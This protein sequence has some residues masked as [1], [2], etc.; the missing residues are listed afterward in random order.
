MHMLL[1]A[2]A[3]FCAAALAKGNKICA[4]VNEDY[5]TWTMSGRN[6]ILSTQTGH[7]L[8]HG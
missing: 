6:E 7:Q 1:D 8:K 3:F 5:R 2:T 4:S